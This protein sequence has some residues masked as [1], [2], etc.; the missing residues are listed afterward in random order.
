MFLVLNYIFLFTKNFGVAI[1]LITILIK[2]LMFPIANKS[3]K[4][5]QRMK[6]LQPTIAKLK[7]QYAGDSIKLNSEMMALYKRESLSPL[8]GCLPLVVQ[9]PVFFSLY[10]VI[11]ISIEMR[12][13]PFFGWIK[14]LS[15]PDPTTIFNLF[16]IIPW[17][18][19]QILMIGIW[20]IIMGLTMFFQQ[21]MNPEPADP[22]QAKVM[23]F[24]PIIF[25]FMF[26]SFPAG[27][28]IYWS[29]SNLLSMIQQFLINKKHE[30]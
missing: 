22:V 18:P 16:G 17:S 25:V 5:M 28:M 9:M 14:D 19:P 13:A 10:K 30:N 29:W 20:P 24:L 6:K 15:S 2:I 11:F 26:Q 27:L 3:F 23:K 21:K 12:H 8:S 1:I 7:E 4:T